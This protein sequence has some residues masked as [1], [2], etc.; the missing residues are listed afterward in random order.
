MERWI[1]FD[2]IGVLAEPSWREIATFDW[3][4]WRAYRRGEIT[5][6]TFWDAAHAAAYRRVIGFRADRL[7]LVRALKAK[8]HR[9]ALATNFSREWLSA[10]LAK[11][12]DFALF[13]AEIVS[14]EVG[15]AKPDPAF[16]AALTR[17]VPR[18]SIFI[19]DQKANCDAAV[20]AGLRAIFAYPGFS[21][22]A[23]I[24]RLLRALD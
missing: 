21:V 9:V 17:R 11:G 24:D 4:A 23:E 14:S 15:A 8:G 3:D 10:L 1:V 22:E 12:G 19:D 16:F 2:L 5:E 13:D 6:A 7:S 18:G 20:R